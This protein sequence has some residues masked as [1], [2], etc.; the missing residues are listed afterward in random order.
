MI[1]P[2][3]TPLETGTRALAVLDSLF[4]NNADLQTLV[5]LDY[6]VV[7]SGDAGG[8]RS[9]HAPMPLRSGELLVRRGIIE[10]GLSLMESRGLIVREA[11]SDGFYYRATE[12][13]T[14]FLA[15]LQSEYATE[16]KARAEW[17]AETFGAFS[18]SELISL[19]RNI[20]NEWT[21]EFQ[22]IELPLGAE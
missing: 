13:S 21:T 2:F 11:S 19:V 18:E 1:S 3:N 22:Q 20:F 4:P 10:R 15:S 17:V 16:L 9:L 5:T 6:L 14:P 7:H 12:T 8:P